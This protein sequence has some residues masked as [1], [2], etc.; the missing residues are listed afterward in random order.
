MP[1]DVQAERAASWLSQHILPPRDYRAILA[2]DFGL[3]DSQIAPNVTVA[4]V[5]K[6][7]EKPLA[8]GFGK[9]FEVGWQGE[10]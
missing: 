2:N 8:T 5:C 9:R 6:G 1:F 10:R 7:S 3:T 4:F